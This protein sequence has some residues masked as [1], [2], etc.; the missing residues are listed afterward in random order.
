ML[1]GRRRSTYLGDEA[2]RPQSKGGQ[3]PLWP[4]PS[5]AKKIVPRGLLLYGLEASAPQISWSTRWWQRSPIEP[6]PFRVAVLFAR[7]P[8][9]YPPPSREVGAVVVYCCRAYPLRDGPTPNQKDP[10]Y[11]NLQREGCMHS[12]TETLSEGEKTGEA[13]H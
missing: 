10:Y 8:E 3:Q 1:P 9:S 13:G 11:Y 12:L 6:S 4:E 7:L 5:E 2:V